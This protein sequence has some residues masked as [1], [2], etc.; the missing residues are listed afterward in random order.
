MSTISWTS[1]Q[2]YLHS[3]LNILDVAQLYD[4]QKKAHD[5]AKFPK[6]LSRIIKKNKETPGCK[7]L[8]QVFNSRFW[9]KY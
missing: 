5:P 8:R 4:S 6:V 1:P 9:E 7:G 3:S 2:W